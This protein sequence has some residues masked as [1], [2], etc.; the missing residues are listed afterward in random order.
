MTNYNNLFLEKVNRFNCITITGL[1]KNTGKTSVLNYILSENINKKR[2]ITSIGYDGESVDQVTDTVKPVIYIKKNTLVATADGL[3]PYCDFTKELLEYT[4]FNTP[5]GEI[6]IVRALSD[7]YAQIAGPSTRTQ[8]E[9]TV[10]QLKKLGAEQIFID[11]AL[12]RKSTAAI[13]FSDAC[14]LATG[15]AFSHNIDKIVEETVYYAKLLSLPVFPD[16]SKV[17]NSVDTLNEEE[18]SKALENIDIKKTIF[19]KGAITSLLIK[20]IFNIKKDLNGLNIIGEDGTRFLIEPQLY[21]DLIRREIK[22]FVQNP[23][24]LI[25][26]TVNPKA[27]SGLLLDSDKICDSLRKELKTLVIDVKKEKRERKNVIFLKLPILSYS[28]DKICML[29]P[30][31]IQ[32]CQI[33]SRGLQHI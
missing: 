32:Q 19:F 22:L 28:K 25:A 16:F 7:G 15:A 13:T 1:A 18:I 14:I 27:P 17:D 8:M 12:S 6:I 21:S 20:Q 4:G 2:A 30:N 3:L 33:T 24:N 26:V 31:S 11:G 10:K 9:A 5:M 29:T 23:I